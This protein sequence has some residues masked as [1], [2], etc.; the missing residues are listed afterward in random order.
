M[1]TKSY[2]TSYGTTI[3]A[4]VMSDL[5]ADIA[6]GVDLQRSAN[7]HIRDLIPVHEHDWDEAMEAYN[8]AEEIFWDNQAIIDPDLKL[9]P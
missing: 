1:N 9:N 3:P 7:D 4:K 6:A 5:I 2:T 8:H